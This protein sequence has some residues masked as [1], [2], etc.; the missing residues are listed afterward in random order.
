M[1][2]MEEI[3][4]RLHDNAFVATAEEFSKNWCWRS[5][6]WY[7]VQKNKG[8]DFSADVAI[9]CLNSVKLSIAKLLLR[10]RQLGSI[11]DSD[12]AILEEVRAR[13]EGYLLD[14]HRIAEAAEDGS[15]GEKC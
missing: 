12:L 13:L 6:S 7:A 5:Q 4:E 2:L 1:T 9:N 10:R 3:Y 14:R 11:A 8:S 15:Q